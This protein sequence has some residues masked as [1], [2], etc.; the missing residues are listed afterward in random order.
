[1]VVNAKNIGA[2]NCPFTTLKVMGGAVGVGES[3]AI[4]DNGGMMQSSE[5]P[6]E[7]SRVQV[8]TELRKYI[9]EDKIVLEVDGVQYTKMQSLNALNPL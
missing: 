4:F 9:D 2:E 8:C 1:M 5:S 6:N 3:K 7:W